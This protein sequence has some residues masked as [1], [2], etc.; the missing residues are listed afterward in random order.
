MDRGL[1]ELYV[2]ILKCGWKVIGQQPG[3]NGGARIII[4]PK[5]MFYEEWAVILHQANHI[6]VELKPQ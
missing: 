2:R 5:D 4:V 1:K 3:P 6:V